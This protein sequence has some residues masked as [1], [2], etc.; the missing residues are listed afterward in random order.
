MN[1]NHEIEHMD[2]TNKTVLVLGGWGLVGSTV[3]R[4]IMDHKPKQIIVTS[5]KKEEAEEAVRDLQKEYPKA[6]KNFFIPWWGNIFVRN[7]F[8]D[9][10]RGEILGD[11]KRRLEM[12]SDIIDDLKD[13]LFYRSTIYH[14]FKKH[15]PD[16]VIDCINSATAIA[17]Q[18]IFQSSRNVVQNITK[19]RKSRA[20]RNR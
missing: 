14:L 10:P 17:Y 5:L 6:G 15:K 12:I 16:I 11:E 9:L 13:D 20:I 8:K 1:T 19:A 4:K 18:D 7:D 2:I 3:N